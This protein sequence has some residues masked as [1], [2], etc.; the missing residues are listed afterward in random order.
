MAIYGGLLVLVLAVVGG[1]VLPREMM[2]EQT[3]FFTLSDAARLGAG[4]LPRIARWLGSVSAQCEIVF[5]AC[6]VLAALAQSVSPW[7]AGFCDWIDPQ[8]ARLGV[9][10]VSHCASKRKTGIAAPS[11]NMAFRA[12]FSWR[13]R[14]VAWRSYCALGIHGL[15]AIC[16]GKGNNG[17]DGF[18]I[19][20]RLDAAGVAVRVLLFT[21][22]TQLTGDAAVNHRILAASGVPREVF[23]PAR[24]MKRL[25]RE[26]A[27]ADWIV[28]ALFGSGLRGPVQ[29]PYD[30]IIAAINASEGAGLCRGHPQRP[31]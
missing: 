21:D 28:D 2:P 16:C 30:R 14:G 15:V 1:C 29:S 23:L 31:G 22:P 5:H 10:Y 18:V 3:Q 9:G 26:L 20:R 12:S 7:P 13:T 6:G 17:G 4:R 27:V 24:W 11:K 25:R 8:S 19:A